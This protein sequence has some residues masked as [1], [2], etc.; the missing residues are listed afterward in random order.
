MDCIFDPVIMTPSAWIA[1]GTTD[2]ESSTVRKLKSFFKYDIYLQ[3]L[4][5]CS[6]TVSLT[7]FII[8]LHCLCYVYFAA[9]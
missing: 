4:L 1:Q 5:R 8:R 2:I 9:V 3:L 7:Y 6:K